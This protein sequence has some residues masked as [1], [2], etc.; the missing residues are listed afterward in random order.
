M[1]VKNI[2]FL[3]CALAL[4]LASPLG[5]QEGSAAP[6]SPGDAN[7]AKA[8]YS[9][10]DDLDCALVL[11]LVLGLR[12]KTMG[13]DERSGIIAGV[14]Y[15]LGRY[16]A[17]SGGDFRVAM[18]ERYPQFMKSDIAATGQQCGARLSDFGQRTKQAGEAVSALEKKAAPSAQ[19]SGE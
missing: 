13:A 19:E 7:A 2:A 12:Q 16:E 3:C 18:A 17:A 6:S 10:E 5:A 8:Q 9:P 15:F 4:V 1:I 11:S 14:A